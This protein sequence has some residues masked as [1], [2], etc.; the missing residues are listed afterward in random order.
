M[1]PTGNN[2]LKIKL[3]SGPAIKTCK[4][5]AIAK[6]LGMLLSQLFNKSVI[7]GLNITVVMNDIDKTIRVTKHKAESKIFLIK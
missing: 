7:L 3:T 2:F 6:F 1:V 5:K 4:G